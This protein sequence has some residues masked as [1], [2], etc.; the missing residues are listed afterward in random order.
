MRCQLL[1]PDE[2]QELESLGKLFGKKEP[3]LARLVL[4]GFNDFGDERM[5]DDIAF[6]QVLK[7]DS[8]DSVQVLLCSDQTG[9]RPARQVNLRFIASNDHF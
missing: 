8:F 6:F 7:L 5:A 2:K 9:L 1:H 3:A 4:V